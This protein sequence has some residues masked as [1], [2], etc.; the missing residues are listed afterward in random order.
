MSKIINY[1]T[2]DFKQTNY[3]YL[4]AILPHEIIDNNSQVLIYGQTPD[5]YQREPEPSHYNRIKDYILKNKD[6]LFPTSIVLA[7]DEKDAESFLGNKSGQFFIDSSKLPSKRKIFRIVDGQHRIIAMREAIKQKSEL[8]NF[9]FNVIILVTK[10]SKRSIEMEIFYDINSKGKRLKVDLIELAR[11]N[12]RILEKDFKEKEI[13]EHIS[14][15]GSF[16]LNEKIKDSVWNNAVKFGI[17]DEQVI[18]IIG[19]NAFRE[20]IG[21][22]VDSYLKINDHEK[23][24]ALEGER[25][26][27]YSMDSGEKIA[28]F[29]HKAWDKTVKNKWKYCFKEGETQIDLFYES[30]KIYYNPQYY[31]QRTMGAKAING[32]LGSI[33]SGKVNSNIHGLNKESLQL[34]DEKINESKITSDDWLVGGT[35]GGYSSESGF[36]KVSKFILNE[37]EI[38]RA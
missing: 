17:H 20:S 21:S 34:F 4:S 7:V 8:R 30:K 1:S 19:V 10:P 14:I 16:C 13:N 15:Q 11:F 36:K 24:K 2:F 38:S 29:I 22:V 37:L 18:G 3:R 9:L 27:K 12:Y 26:V 35:F 32:I 33:V 23:Y 28:E 25:L 6:F 5:G 31:I